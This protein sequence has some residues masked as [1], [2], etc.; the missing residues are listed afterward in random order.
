MREPA[1][2]S[3]QQ[4]NDRES[5]WRALYSN[6]LN[7]LNLLNHL[8]VESLTTESTLRFSKIHILTT[9][10][11]GADVN[12]QG[13]QYGNALQAASLEGYE[14]VALML[15]AAGANVNA[16][17]GEYGNALQAASVWDREKVVQTLLAAGAR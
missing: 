3:R 15:I 14:R 1:N 4:D 2:T 5:F 16:Q 10:A 7:L 17:G 8:S 12:A 11:A 6:S 13:G 9:L